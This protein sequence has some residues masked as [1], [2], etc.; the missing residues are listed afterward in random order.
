[1]PSARVLCYPRSINSGLL[2][3]SAAPPPPPRGGAHVILGALRD[4]IGPWGPIGPWVPG[5]LGPGALGGCMVGCM[6]YLIAQYHKG[7]IF[8]IFLIFTIFV[9]WL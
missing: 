2:L 3:G 8:V 5:L 6:E 7:V 4:A 1:M 9:F